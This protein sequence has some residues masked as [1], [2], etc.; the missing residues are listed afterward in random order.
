[1]HKGVKKEGKGVFRRL[2]FSYNIVKQKHITASQK[3]IHLLGE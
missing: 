3:T 2:F 1:M